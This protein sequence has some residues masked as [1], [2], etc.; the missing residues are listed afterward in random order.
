MNILAKIPLMY[1]K[2]LTGLLYLLLILWVLKRPKS[3]IMR[4]SPSSKRWRDM[5]WWAV[6]LISIQIFLYIIF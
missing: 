4:Q 5:R 1:A 6:V 3:F 2:I